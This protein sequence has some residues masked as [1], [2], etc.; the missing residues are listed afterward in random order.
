MSP[1][2]KATPFLVPTFPSPEALAASFV[3]IT[4]SG[5]FSNN[6]PA[7]REF[8]AGLAEWLDCP[9]DQIALVSS[10]TTGL[11][12]AIQALVD[13]AR[14]N[15]LVASFTF[16]AGPLV[17]TAAS[18]RPIF[19]DIEP[20]TWQPDFDQAEAWCSSHGSSLA[21]IL[22]TSTF[23][24]AVPDIARWEALAAEH[25]VPLVVDSAAGFG[26]THEDGEPV[27]LRGDAEVFSFH[28]TKTLAIGEGGAVR[29]RNASVAATIERLANFGFDDQRRS[30][31]LGTNGKLDELS[32]KIG[33]LQLANL[34]ARLAARQE[35]L[36]HYREGLSSLG[37]TFQPGA[38]RSAL[39]F[40][41]AA[42]PDPDRRDA[43]MVALAAGAIESRSY[44]NPPVHLHP[45]FSEATSLPMAS[46]EDLSSR[47]ISLPM[48]DALAPCEIARICAIV[49]DVIGPCT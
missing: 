32:S 12:L 33:S 4:A 7:S 24:V 28:A 17:I 5:I 27:G 25:G 39:P 19:L 10:G 40:V 18:L 13:P 31:A 47:I 35:I 37:V 11:H 30:I 9:A 21:G 20:S 2:T 29:C 41:S 49:G 23:G 45:V 26:S 44:Y 16:A 22:L 3:E 8:R 36:A 1:V 14:T 48:N 42:L 38:E 15:V 34:E 6:G 46:T 43:V